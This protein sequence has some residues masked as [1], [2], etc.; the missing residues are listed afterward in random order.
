M[1]LLEEC[2]TRGFSRVRAGERLQKIFNLLGESDRKL[3]ELTFNGR[4]SVREAA[5][6]CGVSSGTISRRV[7]SVL[8]RANSP[9][10]LALMREEALLLPGGYREVG[11]RYFLRRM[12]VEAIAWECGMSKYEVRRVIAFLKGWA[13]S[14]GQSAVGSK[15]EM[16]KV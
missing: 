14:S 12:T 2:E 3:V 15:R 13:G 9:I 6:I 5:V 1:E 16:S 8:R 7:R 11:V 10:V 4:L